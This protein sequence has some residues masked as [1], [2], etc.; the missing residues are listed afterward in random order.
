MKPLGNSHKKT[1]NWRAGLP[2]NCAKP[3]NLMASAISP[4]F[5]PNSR[6]YANSIRALSISSVSPLKRLKTLHATTSATWNCA[7]ALTI[8]PPQA[9]WTA[10]KS[11]TGFWTAP[12]NP[13][14]STVSPCDSCSPS[15]GAMRLRLPPVFSPLRCAH[16][17][18]ALSGLTWPVMRFDSRRNPLHRSSPA[19]MTRAWASPS[20]PAKPVQPRVLRR[21]WWLYTRTA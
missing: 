10:T 7:S 11:P 13:R 14:V 9:G 2:S 4:I 1:P 5:F 19:R 6:R 16:V 20:T 15:G 8:L 17:R 12:M 3:L 21:L 18:K